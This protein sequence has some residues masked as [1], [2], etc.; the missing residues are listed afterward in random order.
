MKAAQSFRNEG[1]FYSTPRQDQVQ[2]QVRWDW[3]MDDKGRTSNKFKIDFNTILKFGL[4]LTQHHK[5]S[6]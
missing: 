4:G 3:I 2:A 5:T 1:E 6:L